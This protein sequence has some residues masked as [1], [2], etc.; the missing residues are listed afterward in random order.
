M[1]DEKDKIIFEHLIH[2]CRTTTT[3]LS[4]I[5]NLTQ[6]TIFYRIQKL[7][8]EGYI[9]KYD[10]ILN[11][12]KFPIK[13]DFFFITVKQKDT[14]EFED[15]CLKNKNISSVHRLIHKRNYF[16]MIFMNDKEKEE[17]RNFL[18]KNKFEYD[19]YL[20]KEIQFLP[21]SIYNI[22]I[23][24]QLIQK[25]V[26]NKDIKLDK[27]DV[28]IL[29][30]LTNGGA[31]LSM[32]EIAKKLNLSLDLVIYR[33]K[34]LKNA[35]Y[36]GIFIAQPSITKFHLQVDIILIKTKNITFENLKKKLEQIQKTAY[37]AKLEDNLILTQLLTKDFDE[38]K[39]TL[40][41]IHEKL[42]DNIEY[43]EIYNTQNWLF[44]NRINFDK[45]I[46]K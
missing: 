17:F 24:K 19:E 46:E 16:I 35:G 40:K 43:I 12:N 38:Y 11:W 8:N 18:N 14:K 29:E 34:K 28:K 37:M 41:L 30:L 13:I 25:S 7:E 26:E 21:Y 32:V 15:Y 9:S 23:K 31:K 4:K 10:I 3:Y 27:V 2:D 36:F 5:T 39:K 20:Q 42:E 6:P 22:L 45:L 44:V 1:L 33:Y